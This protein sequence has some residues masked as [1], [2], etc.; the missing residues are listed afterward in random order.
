VLDKA[1]ASY[2]TDYGYKDNSDLAMY[3]VSSYDVFSKY[4]TVN[5]AWLHFTPDS[6]L[7]KL[8]V[9]YRDAGSTHRYFAMR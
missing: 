4:G 2:E 3:K 6:L 1:K 7:Y 8:V 5:S 9:T